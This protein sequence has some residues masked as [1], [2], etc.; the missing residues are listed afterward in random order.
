[1]SAHDAANLELGSWAF[2]SATEVAYIKLRADGAELVAMDTR[3]RQQ[4]VLL[5]PLDNDIVY[6]VA[7]TGDGHLV[8]LTHDD[9]PGVLMWKP[10]GITHVPHPGKWLLVASVVSQAA[11]GGHEHC[12]QP[13]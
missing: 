12:C 6:I 3:T 10:N 11:A 9:P 7:C 1:L 13:C 2:D 5:V 8:M 4:T